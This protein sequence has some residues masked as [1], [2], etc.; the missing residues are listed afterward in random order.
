MQQAGPLVGPHIASRLLFFNKSS[1][2]LRAEV[3][4]A[5]ASVY[6][7]V[8]RSPFSSLFI[9]VSCLK[10]GMAVASCSLLKAITSFSDFTGALAV[11]RYLFNPS[12]NSYFN[13]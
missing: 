3:D 11:A 7:W 2:T 1:I 5:R 13:T 8:F 10:K 9:K 12:L 6:A 4:F